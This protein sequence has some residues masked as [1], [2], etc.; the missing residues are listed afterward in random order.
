MASEF[1]VS[2]KTIRRNIAALKDEDQAAATY[3][4]I[5]TWD[6]IPGIGKFEA[7]VRSRGNTPKTKL[8]NEDLL[9][10]CRKIWAEAWNKKNLSLLDEDDMVAFINWN[11]KQTVA[12]TG[13]LVTQSRKFHN[14][15]ACRLFMRKG[16][17]DHNWLETYLGTK[18]KKGDVRMPA[19]FKNEETFKTVMP[20]LYKALDDLFLRSVPIG[21]RT[22][23]PLTHYE[24]EAQH[25]TE[26]TKSTL[27]VRTGNH[28][29]QREWWGTVI[30]NPQDKG[31]SLQV[32][33]EGRLLHWTVKCKGRETWEIP[34]EAFETIPGLVEEF[35]KFIHDY[36]LKTGD[37]LI[38]EKRLSIDRSRL[39][40][41]A[42]AKQA[43][44]SDLILHDFRKISGT[45]LAYADLRVEEAINFGVGWKD[46]ATYL[47]HYCAVKGVNM[48]RAYAQLTE[49]NRRQAA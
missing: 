24:Y 44:L 32:T 25:L 21:N 15:L 46:A 35:E 37:Y 9:V 10:T 47:K 18:G 36:Q 16:Y 28:E 48:K 19:E 12:R 27:Q 13:K 39:I 41:K 42:Q 6:H 4:E 31:S 14:I 17:G 34:R 2:T 11:D 5:D 8:N 49:F 43:G 30:N 26:H 38:D 1:G 3:R 23:T 45:T 33:P 29:E 20:R 40:L 22:K 7:W